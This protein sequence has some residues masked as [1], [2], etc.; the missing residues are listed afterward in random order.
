MS[1]KDFIS[2]LLMHFMP[3]VTEFVVK[4]SSSKHNSWDQI[5]FVI[6]FSFNM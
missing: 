1:I 5:T 2:F 6:C 3:Y 4:V